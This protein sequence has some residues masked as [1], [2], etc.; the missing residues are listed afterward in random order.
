MDKFCMNCG[1]PLKPGA[2]FCEM[3]GKPVRG[4]A[5]QTAAP[6]TG[7]GF[8]KPDQQTAAGSEPSR[9]ADGTEKSC[10]ADGTEK[11]RREGGFFAALAASVKDL[12][13]HPKRLIPAMV[14]AVVW[15]VLPLIVGLIPEANHPAVR[16]LSTL[17]Y[18][19]GGMFGGFFG[20]VGGIFGKAVFA[21]A[22]T[23]VILALCEKRNPFKGLK[24]GLVGI[25]TSGIAECLPFITAG[26]AGIVLYAF[27]NI[28]SAPQNIAVSVA[29]AV[30]GLQAVAGQN[31]LLFTAVFYLLKWISKGRAPTRRAVNHALSGFAAGFVIAFPLTFLRHPWIILTV[32]LVLLAG[33]LAAAVI[34]HIVTKKSAGT[35]GKDAAI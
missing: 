29:C 15:T 9:Q 3:C 20:A 22:V 6:D 19:N 25:L 10:Q 34:L 30:A 33:G 13:K 7:A 23:T 35:A 32:G 24:S 28:T 14:L 21:A 5:A 16:L 31:G 18:A 11:D 27:F 1:K 4:T 8:V 2:A 26:G 12:L 17:T